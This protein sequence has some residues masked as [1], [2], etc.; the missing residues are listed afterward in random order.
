MKEN[1]YYFLNNRLLDHLLKILI[2]IF[3]K[4]SIKSITYY[5]SEFYQFGENYMKSNANIKIM[6]ILTMLGILFMLLPIINSDVNFNTRNSD[7]SSES[8]ENIIFDKKNLHL[9]LI[10]KKIHINNNWTD[11]ETTGICTGNGT[12]SNPYIIEDLVIDGGGSEIVS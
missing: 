2:V 12:Y 10:S 5:Q 9:S 1:L 11:A 4:E 7:K 8:S 6:M 3:I